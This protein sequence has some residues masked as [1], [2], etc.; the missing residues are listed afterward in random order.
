LGRPCPRPLAEVFRCGIL[1]DNPIAEPTNNRIPLHC[2][3][4]WYPCCAGVTRCVGI[5]YALVLCVR[6]ISCCLF[7]FSMKNA[8]GLFVDH[9]R[10][11]FFAC[12]FDQRMYDIYPGSVCAC[13]RM[14]VCVCVCVAN[15]MCVCINPAQ[16]ITQLQ[17]NISPSFIKYYIFCRKRQGP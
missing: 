7:L 13:V 15:I 17:C 11:F 2:V 14:C 3:G 4:V 5:P 1:T 10:R 6:V 16:I 12:R 8:W 9:V